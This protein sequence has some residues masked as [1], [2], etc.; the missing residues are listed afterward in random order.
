MLANAIR[1][2]AEAQKNLPEAGR[3][4]S[5]ILIFNTAKLMEETLNK[6]RE[7][8]ELQKEATPGPWTHQ[9]P[10]LVACPRQYNIVDTW[11]GQTPQ[12]QRVGNAAFIAGMGSLDL[13]DV[14]RVVES[15]QQANTQLAEENLELR[16]NCL[17]ALNEDLRF[18]LGRPNFWCGPYA[19]VLRLT[20]MEIAPKAEQEQAAV[21]HWLLGQ[22]LKD[23]INW[24]DIVSAEFEKLMA[25]MAADSAGE[26]VASA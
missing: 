26:E 19:R 1:Q 14:V 4:F 21:I 3:P 9:E 8:A 15:L 23:P 12:Q 16:K 2:V 7:V 11:E 17:P 6:L 24:R 13:A 10:H 20:G 5:W 22:Y 18:I 25:S